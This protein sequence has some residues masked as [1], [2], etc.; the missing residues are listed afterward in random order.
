LIENPKIRRYIQGMSKI[1]GMIIYAALISVP[2][3]SAGCVAEVPKD[4][5]AP[6]QVNVKSMPETDER[7]NSVKGEAIAVLAGGCFWCL[8]AAYELVPG[9]LDVESG[10]AGGSKESPSYEQVSAGF[11]GHAEVVRIRYDPAVVSYESLLDLFWKVHD[12]TTKDRQ[13]ADVGS[14]YRSMILYTSDEQKG[15]AI[16]AIEALKPHFRNPI[17]TQVEPLG[18][19]WPAEDYHQ[20][21]YRK[22]PDYGYCQV[23]VAPKVEK[24][25]SFVDSLIPAVRKP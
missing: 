9:V 11:T 12:P 7:K 19:F 5:A 1:T 6:V 15:K 10:Y 17:V 24:A 16:A 20:D 21:F 13:G 14:Q 8:E 3:L 18:K 22:N 2:L 25:K 4:T 23:V